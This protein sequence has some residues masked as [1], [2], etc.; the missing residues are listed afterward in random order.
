MKIIESKL[1]LTFIFILFGLFVQE[2][3]LAA[4]PAV[5]MIDPA[6]DVSVRGRMLTA[7]YERGVTLKFAQALEEILSKR[8][9]CNVIIAR[10]LG[11][12]KL[13]QQVPTFANRLQVDLFIHL[14]VYHEVQSK[15]QAYLYQLTYN[16]LVD[17]APR[18]YHHP[19]L[20]PVEQAH[21]KNITI[22][23]QY[24]SYMQQ[25]LQEYHS[26][27]VDVHGLFGIPIKPLIG[28]IS[29][30]LVIEFGLHEDD[31]WEP[32]VIPLAESLNFI[33]QK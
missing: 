23:K 27:L 1:H 11:E 31:Q 13:P 12:E 5:V 10:T 6:G 22:T 14:A 16:P 3:F 19:M 17:F 29:P 2:H 7:G 25:F 20:I 9:G 15:P 21:F 4:R 28:V 8:L 24:G 33:L 30:G 26:K 32:L 18:S